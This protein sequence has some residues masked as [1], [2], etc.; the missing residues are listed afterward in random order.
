M[1]STIQTGQAGERAACDYLRKEGFLIC[2]LN[3][4]SGHHE[5]DIIAQ[6]YDELHF[7]EVR[8][9]RAGAMVA[10]EQTLTKSKIRALQLAAAHYMALT[11][12]RLEPHFDLI[13]VDADP[14]GG[15]HLRFI[16]D[17]IEAH[18]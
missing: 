17:A 15:L 5:V 8:T 6:R 10:P 18:W 14:A 7:V 4:R 16:A 1:L 9:R 3:W 12:N 13:A 2:E 11:R